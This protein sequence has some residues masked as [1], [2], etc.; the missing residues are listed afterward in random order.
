VTRL[1]LLTVLSTVFLFSNNCMRPLAAGVDSARGVSLLLSDI[2]DMIAHRFDFSDEELLAYYISFLK[3]ISLKLNERTVAFFFNPVSLKSPVEPPLTSCLDT[4]GLPIVLGSY[5]V[6]SALRP[7]GAD[8]CS[9][10]CPLALCFV[11][12]HLIRLFRTLTLNV[13]RV[14]DDKMRKFILENTAVPYFS[15]V[16]QRM[17]KAF[18]RGAD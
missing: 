16:I 9:V 4:A 14:P 8:R 10:Y 1:R 7:Y 3:T 11:L 18:F 15:A 17:C 13:L 6:L 2:N 5:Q 12:C